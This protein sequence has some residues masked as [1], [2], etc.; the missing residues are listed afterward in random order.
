MGVS[1]RYTS[2]LVLIFHVCVFAVPNFWPATGWLIPFVKN[3]KTM[4]SVKV[5]LEPPEDPLPQVS[6]TIQLLEK[7]RIR[8]EEASMA[9]L[10]DVY[11]KMLDESQRLIQETV[12]RA[13]AVF[14]DPSFLETAARASLQPLS[15]GANPTKKNEMFSKL[16]AKFRE[17]PAY[18]PKYNASSII[19]VTEPQTHV[20]S[21]V[22][23]NEQQKP[24]ENEALS[25][26]QV[27]A[28]E[29][30]VDKST[31]TTG[32]A[33]EPSSM[34]VVAN[35]TILVSQVFAEHI[36]DGPLPIFT[37]LQLQS[38]AKIRS[39]SSGRLQSLESSRNAK[40][41]PGKDV[42]T[43]VI[44]KL[45]NS[46][47]PSV[48]IEVVDIFEP[49]SAIEQKIKEIEQK[50]NDEEAK[51]F[52]LAAEELSMLTQLMAQEL[53][54]NI[55]IQMNVFLV[56]AKAVEKTVG[57]TLNKIVPGTT[58][59]FRQVFL[60][61]SQDTSSEN[62][63]FER[64]V[65]LK[66]RFPKLKLNCESRRTKNRKSSSTTSFLQLYAGLDMKESAMPQLNAEQ[67][68]VKIAASDKVYPTVD[69]LVDDM[70]KR[71]DA[72]ERLIREHIFG[73]QIKLMQAEFE[74]IKDTLHTAVARVLALYGSMVDGIKQS[75]IPLM[76]AGL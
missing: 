37:F 49:D 12:T 19:S 36:P 44:K 16:G 71:R 66:R 26:G 45:Q 8:M 10:E 58:G 6:T 4:P 64:C 23:S 2:I 56:D 40:A 5:M 7:Q 9:K 54:K 57:S 67:L 11:N 76:L 74:M 62:K 42:V 61:N 55:Q 1:R 35:D 48:N 63:F 73:L 38:G 20:S 65:R 34:D 29:A 51:M 21:S 53:E 27:L 32:P 52:Q 14:E 70:Q 28:K 59:K 68:N 22:Q 33:N 69:Q 43:N 75:T 24:S 17:V 47:A 31:V 60:H 3:S 50:R 13:M 39:H 30:A 18:I 72:T 41:F 15:Q 25:S 46:A